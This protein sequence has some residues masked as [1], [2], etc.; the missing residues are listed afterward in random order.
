[1]RFR[2]VKLA[3][4]KQR[5]I[6]RLIDIVIQ[7]LPLLA[8]W[9][10][11]KSYADVAVEEVINSEVAKRAS[12]FISLYSATLII[13]IVQWVLIASH[14]QSFGK[15]I[16]NIKIVDDINLKNAGAV[17]NLVLRTWVNALLM[18]NA[19]YVLVDSLLIF[20]KDR[21]CL[22]DYIAKTKVILA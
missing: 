8:I 4:P 14:G 2:I 20:Q 12:L 6:A 11:T 15:K 22:H 10:V 9:Y 17:R 1:M 7:G 16:M 21:K 3:T 19:I 18:G 13:H 5:L